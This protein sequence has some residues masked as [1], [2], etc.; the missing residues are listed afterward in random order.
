MTRREWMLGTAAAINARA[1]TYEPLLATAIYVWT[2]QKASIEDSLAGI[3]RAGYTRVELMSRMFSPEMRQRTAA[4]LKATG[5]ELFSSYIGGTMHQ[6]P[7]AS[8]T[9]SEALAMA[10]VVKPL[11][12]HLI[13][14]NPSPIKERKTDE[15]LETQARALNRL[16]AE[17]KKKGMRLT[18]HQHAPELREEAR[19]W[20]YELRNTDPSL[21]WF[22]VDVD[23]LKRGG[24]DPVALLKE[25]GKRTVSLHVR[26]MRNGVWMEEF[27]DGD[28][29]YR[30]VV[31]YLKEIGYQGYVVVELAYEKGTNPTRPLEENLRRSRL[32]AEKIF[33]G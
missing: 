19:E 7:D 8:E 31:A 23:W 33:F 17:L 26:S 15:Q 32:Y 2:Q 4:G 20:R 16:G 28:I 11:G 9:I 25:A 24:Q 3:K 10:D 12:A 29:D 27:A 18:V 14:V 13:N 22:C 1:V 5:L 21:V 6:E 30:L